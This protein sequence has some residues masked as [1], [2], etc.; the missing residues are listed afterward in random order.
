[1]KPLIYFLTILY[2]YLQISLA[3]ELN[4]NFDDP[5]ELSKIIDEAIV[6]KWD[7]FSNKSLPFDEF[8]Q[9]NGV[10]YEKSQVFLT[11]VI[12]FN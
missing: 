6:G 4:S 8:R 1:M 12:M 9:K 3:E 7:E 2:C 10:Q 11:V 5:I